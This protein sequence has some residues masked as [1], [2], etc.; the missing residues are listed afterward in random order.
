MSMNRL[1]DK[2]DNVVETCFIINAPYFTNQLIGLF[3]SIIGQQRFST[4]Q[5]KL[6]VINKE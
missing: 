2:Y 1:S 3:S 6:M 4:M 5:T